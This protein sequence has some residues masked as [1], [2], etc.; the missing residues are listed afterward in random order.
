MAACTW[1]ADGRI[2]HLALDVVGDTPFPVGV[3]A[4]PAP[5]GGLGPADV[6]RPAISLDLQ[7]APQVPPGRVEAPGRDP[8]GQEHVLDR[9]FGQVG[10]HTGAPGDGPHGAGVP[11]MHLG[12][13]LLAATGHGP[14]E[15]GL[16]GSFQF[17]VQHCYR[18]HPRFTP[19]VNAIARPRVPQR[20]YWANR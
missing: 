8:Q 2:K 12:Q 11:A 19:F 9:L 4:F 18:R 3:L 16:T 10:G 17:L 15:I 14:G 7:V 6:D 13:R 20:G 1:P 5:A